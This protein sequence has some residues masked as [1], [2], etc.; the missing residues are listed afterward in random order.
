MNDIVKVSELTFFIKNWLEETF[1][2][3]WITG[4]I[5]NLSLP[6]SGHAYFSL[7]DELAQVRCV[8]FKPKVLKFYNQLM[9]GLQVN[10]QAKVTLYPERGDFQLI[11]EE[12]QPA[13]EGILVQLYLALVAKLKAQGLFDPIHKK[14]IPQH[15]C[16]IGIITSP[17]GAAVIDVLTVLKRR[18]PQIPIDVYPTKVQGMDAPEEIIQALKRANL[19]Q[20]V[21]VLILTRGGG[22][23][24]DL[25]AFNNEELAHAIFKSQIPVIS[26]VGHEVDITI[27]DMVADLRA[28]T[29]SA[30]AELVALSIYQQYEILVSRYR[31]LALVVKQYLEKQQQR[32][33]VAS[34]SLQ[35]PK[36]KLNL[37]KQ[38]LVELEKR[39][40]ALIQNR[41]LNSFQA[42]KH[43]AALLDNLSPLT[44]LSR[45]Y[46]IVKDAHG[47]IVSDS[48]QVNV[49]D[50]LGIQLGKGEILCRLEEILS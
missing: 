38:A 33:K 22:S 12:L 28:A 20:R 37:K 24:E 11:V 36:D 26:A 27:S 47:H 6:A 42:V 23:L 16:R 35:H 50:L 30:A 8:F 3:R 44:I 32:L 9:N 48:T 46:A 19:D 18:C 25:W 31:T 34:C 21:D 7:K 1:P 15:P 17:T 4:E 2:A 13:G 5:S 49:D 29:P 39:L 10:V 45:G 43:K 40:G 41:L 14:P